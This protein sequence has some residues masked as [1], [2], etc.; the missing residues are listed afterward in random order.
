M[1]MSFVPPTR[2]ELLAM[3]EPPPPTPQDLYVLFA[4]VFKCFPFCRV[5]AYYDSEYEPTVVQLKCTLQYTGVYKTLLDTFDGEN[6]HNTHTDM[7]VH[8]NIYVQFDG[9]GSITFYELIDGQKTNMCEANIHIGDDE[10]E[11]G[12]VEEYCI[13]F[14]MDVGA[15][16]VERNQVWCTACE[17]PNDE[18]YVAHP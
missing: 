12:N 16:F 3:Y 10:D 13:E 6:T 15:D 11:D 4:I 2:E 14:S 7:C 8:E 9:L 17:F 1:G 5:M 18:L